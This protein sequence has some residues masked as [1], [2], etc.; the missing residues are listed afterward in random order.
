MWDLTELQQRIHEAGGLTAIE[1]QGTLAPKWL[2][3]ASMIV[4][5]PKSPGMGE[6]FEPEKF[7]S[8]L[9]SLRISTP[10]ALK[11]VI[12]SQQDIDFALDVGELATNQLNIIHPGMRFLSLGNPFPPRMGEDFELQENVGRELL[13]SQL[14]REYR[15]LI[16]DMTNDRRVDDWKFLPQLHVLAF[17]N[18]VGR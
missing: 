3:D 9:M 13:L 2:Q 8:F 11:I 18:E 5:S 6:K 4:V 12:F 14:M 1:T 17:G 10:V 15:L 7:K 16:E